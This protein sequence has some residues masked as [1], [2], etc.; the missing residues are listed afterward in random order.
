M[1]DKSYAEAEAL[2][3]AELTDVVG[4]VVQY[5]AEANLKDPAKPLIPANGRAKLVLT[6]QLRGTL[7]STAA[8][9]EPINHVANIAQATLVSPGGIGCA[10][11]QSQT[12]DKP[13]S[14]ASGEIDIRQPDYAVQAGKTISPGQ[15]YEDEANGYTVT[16]TGQPCDAD[17]S[18]CQRDSDK[19]FSTAR[20]KL[21]TLTDD[22]PTFWNAF[23]LDVLRP[24]T[25]PSPVNQ[26]RL[27]V[28]TG[29][30]YSLEGATLVAK[31]E[32]NTDLAACWRTGDW[33]TAVNQQ[34]TPTL[35]AG[36]T[37]DQVLGLRFEAQRVA[38]DGTTVLQW[39]RPADP[40]LSISFTTKQR[41]L[42]RYGTDGGSTTPVPSTLPGLAKAP[43][44]TTQGVTTDQLRVD[45]LAAWRNQGSPWIA[46]DQAVATTTLNHRVN[47]I[48]V[49]KT[50]GRGQ[51]TE[52][53][54]YDLDATIPY[55]FT[56][57]NIGDW[58]MTGLE[59]TDTIGL[60]DG[61]SKLVFADVDPK[62]TVKVNGVTQTGFTLTLDEDTGKLALGVPTEFRLAPRGVLQI[63]ANLRFRDRL[64]A[65]TEVANTLAVTS[66]R[67]FERCEYTKDAIEQN[68]ITTGVAECAASTTVVA[69]ASTP[70]T[71]TK[72]VKGSAAGD[73]D[74]AKGTDHYNDLGVISVYAANADECARQRSLG[75]SYYL[76]NCV[77]ITR[78]GG[79]ETWRLSLTNNGNVAANVV[80]AIDVL[81]APGD[82]GVTVNTARRSR[83]TPTF[84][85]N[86]QVTGLSSAAPH[87]LTYY[88]STTA[89]TAACNKSDI[90]NDTK[91]DG[92]ANCGTTWIP[93]TNATPADELAKA[94]AI[95]VLLKFDARTDGLAPSDP[96]Y[97]TFDTRTPAYSPV[98]DITT[99][100]PIAWNS[101]AVG[102]RTAWSETFPWRASLI[103]EPKKAGVAIA[104]GQL[105]LS[106]SVVTPSGVSWLGL[107]PSDYKATVTCTSLGDKTE[108]PT[109]PGSDPRRVTLPADGAAVSLNAYHTMN[110]PL[111]ADCTIAEDASQG[112]EA[113]V[114]PTKVTALRDY[115][116][117]A[118][119]LNGW[120]AGAPAGIATVTN[121]YREAGFTVSKTVD[122]PSALQAD[123]TT[124]VL[125]K[126]FDFTA[127]CTF[128]GTEVLAKSFSL[129]PNDKEEFRGLPAG[130]T[131]S[132]EE[133]Y[134]A[135][136]DS[137]SVTVTGGD[138]VTTQ[139]TKVSFTLVAGDETATK[140]GY[141][142]T[143]TVGAATITKSV[144]G[145]GADQ[146][147]NE[148]FEV[149]LVCTH[150]DAVTT[151][152][153]TATKTL[154][155]ASPNWEVTNLASG[156]NCA[157]TETK[158]GGANSTTITNGEFAVGTDPATP[159]MVRVENYFGLGQVSVTK[160]VFANGTDVATKAPWSNGVFPVTLSCTRNIDGTDVPITIPG[161]ATKNLKAGAW[162]ATWSNLPASA[163]CSVDENLG[164]ITGVPGQPNPIK[165]IT[166]ASQNVPDTGTAA[167]T[168]KNDYRA[169][170]LKIT[171]TLLGAGASFFSG[172]T[173]SV[174][175]TMGG[176]TVYSNNNVSVPKGSLAS[177]EL[178]PIPFGSSCLA[179]ETNSG[180]A[181]ADK[182]PAPQT[183][184]IVD[185]NSSN[186][187]FTA[188]F[189]NQFSA[190]QLSITKALTGAAAGE[191]WAT[192]ATF[193]FS[194]TCTS[195]LDPSWTYSATDI[196][197]VG[198]G[199]VKVPS[200]A[201]PK[202]LPVGAKCSVTETTKGGATSSSVG[203]PVTVTAQAIPDDIQQLSITATNTYEYAGLTVSKTVAGTTL[204][205]DQNNQNLA[206]PK[207]VTFTATCT[208]DNSTGMSTVLNTSFGIT[209]DGDGS[210]GSKSFE[211]LPSGAS[212]AVA[213]AQ[214]GMSPAVTY[215]LTRTGQTTTTGTGLATPSF[216]L[217]TGGPSDNTVAF[218]NAFT[219][220]KLQLTKTVSPSN[221]TWATAPFTLHV[222][223]TVGFPN[224]G[225][226]VYTKDVA[227][228]KTGG[229][230]LI[231]NLPTNASCTTTEPPS[232]SGG[233]NST[234]ITGGTRTIGNGTT[235]ST[236]VTNTFTTG[237][238]T[239]AK[240]LKV[241]G[242]ATTAKP[243]VSASYWMTLSCTR[244]V[245]GSSESLDLS[246]VGGAV[247]ELKAPSFA[248]TW[249][250][251]PRGANCTATETSIDYPSGTP[252][253]PPPTV[254]Y[255]PTQALGVNVGSTTVT[256][257]VTNDFKFGS[258]QIVKSLAGDAAA[259][260]GKGA[261]SFK[262]ECT[263][264]GSTGFV[265]TKSDITL[266]AP[267]LTSAEIGPIPQ[268][269]LCSVTETGTAGAT[270]VE[271]SSKTITLG[272]I[273]SGGTRTAAFT[274]TFDFAGFTVTKSVDNGGA[275][276][277]DGTTP[278][279]YD[280]TYHFSASCTHNGVNVL[281]VADFTLK[282][283]E[284]KP[285]E[286]LPVG[287][288]CRVTETNTG[289]AAATKYQITQNGTAGSQTSGV[290][291]PEFPLVAGTSPLA[292][293]SPDATRV[294][295]T[296]SYTTGGLDLTKALAGNGK[297]AWGTGP[298]TLAL[299]CTLD[300]DANPGTAAVTVFDGSKSVAGG[301]TWAVTKLPTGASCTVSEPKTGGA[302]SVD[303][304]LPKPTITSA[305]QAVKI[306]NAFWVGSVRV[307]KAIAG[308]LG[309]L[310]PWKDTTF[311][312]TLAC[313]KDFNG[314]GTPESFVVPNAKKEIK[315]PGS[316]QWDGLPEGAN[317]GVA[318]TQITYPDGT[319]LPQP[320]VS[321]AYSDPVEV[322]AGSTVTQTVTN[323]FKVAKV[324]IAKAITGDANTT[325][326]KGPFTF[327]VACTLA[328]SGD[329][330]T[331]NV[332]L[333]PSAGQTSLASAELGPIPHGSTCVVKETSAAGATSVEPVSG[334]VT[335][336][337]LPADQ[338]TVAAFSNEFRFA[339][340]TVT[341]SVVSAA[342]DAQGGPIGYKPASFTAS[343]K[344]KGAEVLTNPS[345]RAFILSD[346]ES[347][348]FIGL[349]SGADCTVTE[350]GTAGAASTEVTIT[351]GAGIG[352]ATAT[353][354]KFAL[355]PGDEKA[356][357]V[358]FANHYTVGSLELT[359]TVTGEGAS[360][361]GG[362][363]FEAL[364]VCT[365]A[366][367][368][369]TTVY[370]GHVQLS[371]ANP[372]VRIDN[373]AK[374]AACTVTETKDGG[375]N[376][377]EVTNGSPRI[378]NGT[379][380]STVITNTFT[381]GAIE[382]TKA[383]TVDGSPTT[384]KPWTEGKYTVTLAC[385]RD[386]DGDSVA[387]A[388]EVPDGAERI[389]TGAGT[390]T[391]T[392]LPTGAECSVTETASAPV[393]GS[394][395]ITPEGKLTVGNDQSVPS[396]FT[397]TNDFGTTTLSVL[398]QLEGA[399]QAP[400]GNGPFTFEATCTLA[401]AKD[402][403][404]TGT[405]TLT[406]TAGSTATSL[407]GT[408]PGRV[409]VGAQCTTRET[410]NGGADFTP[411]P[412][413]L[414]I[415]ADAAKNVATFTNKFSAGT[416]TLA[417]T[418]DGAAKAE[419]WATDATFTVRVTCE[420]EVD[421]KRG[422]V[423]SSEVEIMGGQRVDV[424]DGDKPSRVPLGSH[425]WAEETDSQGAGKVTIAHHDWDSALVVTD[426]TPDQLQSLDLSV[427]NTFE[428]AGFTVTKAVDNG[429]AANESGEP[430]TYPAQFGFEAKCSFENKAGW[431]WAE[432]FTLP[433][434]GSK[435]FTGLPAG[436][437]CT[438]TENGTGNAA[439]TSVQLTQK[440]AAK[441]VK[442]DGSVDFTLVRGDGTDPAAATVTEAAFT[443][444][445]TIGALTITKKLT[446]AG[447][448]AWG[449]ADFTIE[450]VCT[451]D[452]DAN[453]AT[454]DAE[455]YRASTDLSVGTTLVWPVTK[456]PTGA[457]CAVRETAH[458]GA[459]ST[460][461]TDPIPLIGNNPAEPSAVSVTNEFTLGS[462]EVSKQVLV[463]GQADSEA[464]PYNT[465]TFQVRLK[466]SR[467]V[468]GLAEGVDIPGDDYPLGN[469]LDG[470]RTITGSGGYTY[471]GL[472]TGADCLV[473]EVGASLPLPEDRVSI[474]QPDPVATDPTVVTALVSNDYHTGSLQLH[475]QLTGDGVADWA[476]ADFTFDVSCTLLDTAEVAHTVFTRTD[477]VL[478]RENPD[479][480]VW[481]G[482]P[483]GANCVVTETSDGGADVPAEETKVTIADGEA[484]VA[485]PTNEF[486]LGALK[487][488]LG[489]TLDGVPTTADPFAG[490]SY[491]IAV[492]CT[493][494]VNGETV[495]VPVPDGGTWT[496]ASASDREHVF[497]GLPVGSSCS[498]H[499]TSASLTPQ[500]VTYTPANAEPSG[501]GS[502]KVKIT[503]DQEAPATL[504]VID[505]FRTST[506]T[507]TKRLTGSGF[508]DHASY[509]FTITVACTLAED[510]VEVPHP[511]FATTITLSVTGGLV[512][513]PL[514]PIPVGSHCVV[515]ETGT[516]G[517]T[518][519]AEPA[520]LDIAEDAPNEVSLVNAFNT[521][522][523]I[524]T[525]AITVDGL[526]STAEPY[527][528]ASY[529][530]GL[531][532]TQLVDDVAT[533]VVIPGGATRTIKGAGSAQFDELPLGAECTVSETGST[534]AIPGDQVTI[535]EPKVTVGAEPVESV[536][537]N[538]FRT[539][540]LA[541]TWQLSGVGTSFAG[542]AS[543]AV[544]CTL[545]GATG[546][547][548][549]DEF[550]LDPPGAQTLAASGN[551]KVVGPTLTPIPAGAHCTVTQSGAQGADAVASAVVA[552]GKV[553][554][555]ATVAN[556]YSAGTL[557]IVKQLTGK[558]A[559]H[560]T[561][562]EFAFEVTCQ[563]ADRTPYSSDVVRITG[564]GS[565]TIAGAD[566]QAKLFPAGVHCWAVETVT[567]GADAHQVDRPNFEQA[568]T[569]VTGQ[570][571]ALQ[572]MQVTALNTF[573]DPNAND[574]A[575]DSDG[576]GSLAFTGFAGWTL[577]GLGLALMFAGVV[578][579]LRRRR[580]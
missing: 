71:V 13:S 105:N 431:T 492:T 538:D 19:V 500:D 128:L 462:V 498:V 145:P 251:L 481:S 518:I 274:N 479:S 373:L 58:T 291:T 568:A 14:T 497:T 536:I 243:W 382:V 189:T 115:S 31:C 381:L 228:P 376:H 559:R 133:T 266:Q 558:G 169:G 332:T 368:T 321:V 358:G 352:T 351:Q 117:M 425:C 43:G 245:N 398:K 336:R 401:G 212:C 242:V 480:E 39:E 172:A 81:P 206:Y 68:A 256:Q 77:P 521:G 56:V 277:A 37:A 561:G 273:E 494:E 343:C 226:P 574:N 372:V 123:G 17:G 180:G 135:G 190:G 310:A 238:V 73:P 118:N 476:D 580:V 547:T 94:R 150:A 234:T 192:K 155:K 330:Y 106:K 193:K 447:A 60:V 312:F 244:T 422:Q 223:C 528:S 392:K 340:F 424:L 207:S 270:A 26:L 286:N 569:V 272:A 16:L 438:V 203:G 342:V 90:L 402:P 152:V 119:V 562:T 473:S 505:H 218:E 259:T 344:F 293:P 177:A 210:W 67:A 98:A 10:D 443:N 356:T 161:E 400:F 335:L 33:S 319:P 531:A 174:E 485:T 305:V 539:G 328:G 25:L 348:A 216:T 27:S 6:Y 122:G 324:Q 183:I 322:D 548:F 477:I 549:R 57:T 93:F 72:A 303:I 413:T 429:T 257:T 166:P 573:D 144:T 545:D 326:G 471:T 490:G 487:V 149:K 215:A 315:G 267:N 176:N 49:E 281:N 436:A 227:F 41:T 418:L 475:K 285:F 533:P 134:A 551:L 579:V 571:Q 540:S 18:R 129:S 95:K 139:G 442:N 449:Q 182:T 439:S 276:Q 141:T 526:P 11:D 138:K 66:D 100:E 567:G 164:G 297:D 512:S 450:L 220:G 465:A 371:R 121:T 484:T 346:K 171:K 28:L 4:V 167:F 250:G 354:A 247:K 287:A 537:T 387:E 24:V 278:V 34:V 474:D 519:G 61:K 534:L 35:P 253:Q 501:V 317:C 451:L 318:E 408:L 517:A 87:T 320:E 292:G 170:K 466:C 357:R 110:L 109:V 111:F 44:E 8:P 530:V 428:Y 20:T 252:T 165:T 502:G 367:A 184:S 78:P 440:G 458:G 217:V 261:F 383:L 40:K 345:D 404:Y 299:V 51:A 325:W 191:D 151:P 454:P 468:N 211:R 209:G 38:A 91:P 514:G 460:T 308:G 108:L 493:R 99:V 233:A 304:S 366:D 550:T 513:S 237:S 556:E 3:P 294:A 289:N 578:L 1:L 225:T 411:E 553:N 101:V 410:G 137:T 375:A 23:D 427:V 85:G 45:G 79:V 365:L 263:L 552:S 255:S 196:T 5:G 452:T 204:A 469:D 350:T 541:V 515:T 329:V 146:W 523:V 394:T 2:M 282:D 349:P 222:A 15:R 154:S 353:E 36:I 229:T 178:G 246:K 198:A 114:N 264:E 279:V 186:D 461:I 288:L 414:T 406:R 359:K 131:C 97:V 489:L 564:A 347:H 224:P 107:L 219:V 543:F 546:W 302:N 397:V 69:A 158:A 509:P 82:T 516:G 430:I 232:G 380:A 75:D 565:A 377:T 7:R 507:V 132:V 491:A 419:S 524:V 74:A 86:V 478:S 235:V 262:V 379:I 142:N 389:I 432:N 572:P 445:F 214:P 311:E 555:T 124:P 298:F 236:G 130:A 258:V 96:F 426:G 55:T 29:V 307:T 390:A 260:W 434:S 301:E 488:T 173:F 535:S 407:T 467:M 295:F 62:Y 433:D 201:S 309:V 331:N 127:S 157:V 54:R 63:I 213:E 527:A 179:T 566:G 269:S 80:S 472:P 181:D 280:A 271:P 455:V 441:P 504:G 457:S 532:C 337:N 70:L 163:E 102:S 417:K 437:D 88:Y 265:F 113:T 168:V 195:E 459:N 423:F 12:C 470:V 64:A 42:L 104:S 334:E 495:D 576:D 554:L 393:A 300:H 506:L 140:I 283:K 231:E 341:K 339:G 421:G 316:V 361:W 503:P 199:T 577:G 529:T 409:P 378:G 53:P 456:L 405:V 525:K 296:N 388:I 448:D 522:S 313:T 76:G 159:T 370:S 306:T 420:A 542:P 482:I 194:V 391:Y 364:V 188:N 570:P 185:P 360:L 520:E 385:T 46:D 116:G 248:A 125:F 32:G 59:L 83:F 369:P 463:D 254:S 84:L 355:V 395:R 208:F 175:C 126:D 496:F 384:A 200:N 323:T 314:D 187:L 557:T 197:L 136:A 120:G 52:A 249:S 89:P 9:V 575:S 268:G 464:E 399:G 290:T 147:G 30:T 333:T 202:L 221:A 338:T 511:V 162:T 50:P 205:K 92:Q 240:A 560:E 284:A 508:D 403:V 444:H 386:F 486:N 103:T 544:E 415:D 374:G 362:A 275:V 563:L 153:F 510:G 483:V 160:Q 143:Y 148:N 65:G 416:I 499:Q 435:A 22:A 112:A 453:P 396:E 241:N 239:I 47:Q 156:A 412:V 363:T 446:G 327:S 48:R 230:S 21:L